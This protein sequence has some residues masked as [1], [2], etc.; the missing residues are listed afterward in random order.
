MNILAI[1]GSLRSASY[2]TS[3]LR[4]AHQYLPVD[5]EFTWLDIGTLPLYNEELDGEDVLP[6]V[7][8]AKQAVAAADGILIATPEYN[9]GIPGGL[10][11]ALDWCSRPAYKSPIAHKPALVLSAS[12]SAVGGARAQAQLKQVLAAMLVDVHRAPDFLVP[13]AQH[14]FAAD[15]ALIDAEIAQRLKHLMADFC[16][17][18]AQR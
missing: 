13:S 2:N 14:A 5:I 1:S 7:A 4:A 18:V 3:L 12:K 8:A 9:Y 11:N 10:K 6:S 16:T 17:F 15:G